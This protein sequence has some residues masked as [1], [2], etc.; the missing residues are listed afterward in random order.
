MGSSW[1]SAVR[2]AKLYS[3]WNA[4]IGAQP[5]S[6]ASSC[7]ARPATP[8]SS[9]VLRDGILAYVDLRLT[10]G[11]SEGSNNRI[12]MI[13]RRAFG[14]HTAQALIAMILFACGQIGAALRLCTIDWGR[15]AHPSDASLNP[16]MKPL[17]S[18]A[19]SLHGGL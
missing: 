3:I 8:E 6:A 19:Q 4:A 2:S 10:N 1:R 5:R 7:L 14:Y 12:R 17:S 16:M 9:T 13:A 15:R 11:L 18:K